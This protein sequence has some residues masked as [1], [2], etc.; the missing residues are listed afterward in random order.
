MKHPSGDGDA[1][2]Q[3]AIKIGCEGAC[4]HQVLS[5]FGL[6]RGVHHH[7]A[8]RI[9]PHLQVTFIVIGRFVSV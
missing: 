3:F 8:S 1:V 7:V 9:R 5:R 2:Y 4:V 6:R